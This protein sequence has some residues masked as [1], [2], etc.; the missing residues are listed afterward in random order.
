M[1]HYLVT[2]A[3]GFIG[4]RV[5][6]L[7]LSEG[8]R[9]TGLDELNAAYDVRLK[10]WRLAKL[11]GE[12]AFEFRQVDIS[13]RAALS[14]G[15]GDGSYDA[16][17]NLA[18]RAGVRA[19]VKDPWVY[20]QANVTGLINLLEMCRERGVSKIVQ[21]STSSLYGRVNA[22]PFR[23]DADI[24]HPLSPYTAT[25]GASELLCHTYHHLYGLDFSVVRYFTVYGPAGR[26]DMSIF[27]FI[28][29][30][31]EDRAV[32]LYGDGNQE[33]DFTYIDDIARGTVAALKPF[34]YEVI[35]LGGDRPWRLLDV[36][37]QIEALLGKQAE[38]TQHDPEPADVPGT[39]ADISKARSLLNWEP[40]VPL[41]RGLEETVRWYLDERDWARMVDTD[42]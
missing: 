11:H 8:H 29:W 19:S 12:P 38:I 37:H 27:R 34:G 25:K 14:Q 22:R 36:L 15:W 1:K 32:R 4:A 28:Q 35:N 17:L 7:L 39:W 40:T 42:D 41:E 33:R 3:A 16:V 24:S 26:P 6:A 9:V 18:A 31:A 2:G 21:A 20:A 23:E 13:D 5:A 10:E 30:I